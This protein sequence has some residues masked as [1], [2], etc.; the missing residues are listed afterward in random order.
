MAPKLKL[1]FVDDDVAILG[2]LRRM[3]RGM[4]EEWDMRFAPGGAEALVAIAADPPDVVVADMRMPGI[5]GAQ[6]LARVRDEHPEIIRLILSGYSDQDL[7]MQT[8]M[9]AH[10]FLAK[11]CTPAALRATIERVCQLREMMTG[12]DLRRLVAGI[13]HLP[14]LPDLYLQITAEL[15]SEDPQIEAVIAKIEC[16]PA[17]SAKL[18]QLVNSG[19]FGLPQAVSDVG[20]AARLLGVEVLQ[21]VVLFSGVFSAAEAQGEIPL[22]YPEFAAHALAVGRLAQALAREL[23][24]SPF[25]RKEAFTA[26]ILHDM[27]KLI[28]GLHRGAQYGAILRQAEARG[29]GLSV[30]ERETFGVSHGELGSYL[31]SLWGLPSSLVEAVAYHNNPSRSTHREVGTLALVHIADILANWDPSLAARPVLDDFDVSFIEATNLEAKLSDFMHLRE[32]MRPQP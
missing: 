25:I 32:A 22:S 19:F 28:L 3:L 6:L 10:Q 23:D 30:L 7:V 12:E 18:L 4:R 5:S 14:S 15:R 24:L 16:D 11:P 29:G 13:D 27:G 8:L 1:L 26:G 31:L 20:E 17:L 2:G 21:A 9:V